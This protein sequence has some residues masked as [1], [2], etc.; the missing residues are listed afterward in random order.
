MFRSSFAMR[1]A[2]CDHINATA[3]ITRLS[4]EQSLILTVTAESM[5]RQR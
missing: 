4:L 2:A 3:S 1:T 5:L